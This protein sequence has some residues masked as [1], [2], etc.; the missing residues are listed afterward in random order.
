M[1]S[2]LSTIYV[3]SNC[4]AQFP[5]W[6]GRCLE[7]G[8]WGTI[9]EQTVAKTQKHKNGEGVS[10]EKTITLAEVESINGQRLKTNIGEFDRVL[11]GGI[12]GG[13]LILLGGDPGVGKS[14]LVL[15]I[16]RQIK[17]ILYI[18]GEESGQQLK[19]RGERLNLDLRELQFLA[20]TEI[21]K[22][23]A[24]ISANKP[25]LVII[26]SIQTMKN[27]DLGGGLSST[28]QITSCT[29]QLL[30]AAKQTNI[31]II[32]IGHVTKDGLVAG[33]KSLEHL[34]DVVLYLE[35]DNK[36]YDKILRGVKNRF[37]ST[38]EIG[39]FEM[40]AGG[41][42]EAV[43]PSEIFFEKNNLALP[44]TISTVVM[45]GSRPFLVEVQAL[46]SKTSFGYPQRR[47]TGF[48]LN[49]LQM[50]VAVISKIA[51]FN[52][53]N[54]DIYLNIAGGLKIKETGVDLAVAL[55]LVSAYLEVP[56]NKILAFGEIGLSGEIR[57]IPQTET[58]LR[59]ANKLNFANVIM[60]ET[61]NLNVEL[62]SKNIVIVNNIGQAIK[63]INT[64][65]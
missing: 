8:A 19:I 47:A 59:E 46:V 57:P 26:D 4:E 20:E 36:N 51:K 35:N 63:A 13:A 34:V 44:G 9:K 23:I 37:G 14:T 5:K 22:I 15:Q 48:D 25:P 49:R 31:P 33:P 24:T 60:P 56:A 61:K 42:T 10:A 18:S 1:T 41:L 29:V 16:A 40:T 6:Q 21:E 43:N 30:A 62:K 53:A 52:L 50:I 32:I 11:G 3:C 17:N 39:I 54:Y 28:T 2:Q 7:C 12:V 38:G 27:S 55:A 45:E 58:R 65:K 64:Q